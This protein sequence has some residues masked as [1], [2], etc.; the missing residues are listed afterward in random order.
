MLFRRKKQRRC[1][2]CIH[3]TVLDEDNVRCIKKGLRS[4]DSKCFSFS[5][6]PCKRMPVKGKALD[7]EKYE[8]YDFSL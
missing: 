8:A 4:A 7:P 1:D 2:Q 6:D 5:Y 3:A